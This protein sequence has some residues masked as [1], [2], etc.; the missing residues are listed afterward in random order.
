MDDAL[1]GLL[2]AMLLLDGR[3]PSFVYP[4]L[5]GLGSVLGAE[6]QGS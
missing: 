3:Y 5:S 2:R 6:P 1:S 4:A